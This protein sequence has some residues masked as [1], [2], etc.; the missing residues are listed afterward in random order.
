LTDAELIGVMKQNGIVKPAMTL[1]VAREVELALPLACALL[2]QESSGGH[3]VFGHDNVRNPIKGGDV[4]KARYLQYKRYRELGLGSNGVGPTQLTWSGYQDRAD[5]LGG[6]WAYDVNLSVGFGILRAN[7]QRSGVYR[8]YWNYNGGEA[9]ARQVMPKVQKWQALLAAPARGNVPSMEPDR[10]RELLAA[11]RT[12]IER[13]LAQLRHQDDGEAADEFDEANRATD[14]YQDEFDEGR[15][16]DVREQ[17]AAVERA[18]ARL[19]AGTYG[20]S[21]ESSQPIPDERLEAAPTAE[22]TADEERRLSE[23]RG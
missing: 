17:L 18:E 14:L 6:C 1:R 9:Y 12:R 2:E 22:R 15:A 10:A 7:I 8:G 21:I 5:E 19:A 20:V 13:E 4:T 3:N 16:G 11:E 23:R